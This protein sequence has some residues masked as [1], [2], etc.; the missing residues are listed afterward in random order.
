MSL[1]SS[2]LNRISYAML[3][4]WLSLSLSLALALAFFLRRCA[5]Q[6]FLPLCP[7][8]SLVTGVGLPLRERKCPKRSMARMYGLGCLFLPRLRIM[9]TSPSVL[10]G[11][12]VRARQGVREQLAPPATE[13][14]YLCLFSMSSMYRCKPTFGRLVSAQCHARIM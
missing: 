6:A 5:T 11:H 4:L 2:C 10:D 12:R 9:F 14:Q 13:Q 1:L 3:S 7:C 8:D